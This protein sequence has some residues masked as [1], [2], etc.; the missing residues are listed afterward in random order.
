MSD[1]VK[2][3]C[4]IVFGERSAA[5]M[6]LVL[7]SHSKTRPATGT[8]HRIYF[9][10]DTGYFDGFGRIGRALAPFDLAAVPIGAY[11][12]QA[13]MQ[14]HHMNPEEAVQ[15]AV[16][17]GAKRAVAV[18]YGTFKLSDEPFDEPPKRFKTAAED[19]ALGADGAWLLKIGETRTF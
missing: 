5:R 12:P 3:A 7:P 17:L 1:E 18:H 11:E 4:A 13:M 6:S 14:W 2:I 8:D 9:A 15:A 16:D 10:G 19:T